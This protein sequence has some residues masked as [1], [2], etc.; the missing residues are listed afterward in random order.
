M[1]SLIGRMEIMMK[2]LVIYEPAMCCD[3]GLC[4]VGV[5]SELLRMS[6]VF[7]ALKEIGFQAERFNLNSA[8]M[9]FMKNEKVNKELEKGVDVLPLT[10]VDGEIV[11]S[12]MYPTNEEIEQWLSVKFTTKES[13][14]SGGCGCG[15]GCSCGSNCDCGSSCS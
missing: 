8:P 9:E 2:K 1:Y 10:L 11:K 12:G 3:T 7:S 4:G 5:D 13:Q 6:A 14:A 15:S